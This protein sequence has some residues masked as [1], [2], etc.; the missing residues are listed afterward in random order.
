MHA[1]IGCYFD[2]PEELQFYQVRFRCSHLEEWFG[3]RPF[4]IR[5]EASEIDGR[6]RQEF[7]FERISA[8]RCGLDDVNFSA[9][10]DFNVQ[11]GVLE[12]HIDY[13]T[14]ASFGRVTA[15]TIDQWQEWYLQPFRNFLALASGAHTRVLHTE[16]R[17]EPGRRA[18]AMPQVNTVEL[19]TPSLCYLGE[20][21][22]LLGS[23]RMLFILDDVRDQFPVVL[24]NW[25][26]I[27]RELNYV[28]NLY[29]GARDNPALYMEQ[30]LLSTIQALEGYQRHLFPPS[31]VVRRIDH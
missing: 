18:G 9:G 30:Q 22:E 24:A 13:R 5:P 8:L 26:T 7:G 2:A 12:L 20:K 27:N 3:S 19:I 23:N 1:L 4:Y 16:F 11:E 31:L 29:F 21:P 15:L 10:Q 28:V 14:S 6:W 17:V 25:L